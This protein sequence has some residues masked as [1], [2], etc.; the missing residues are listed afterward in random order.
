[1]ENKEVMGANSIL[2]VSDNN[3]LI[4]NDN[5]I[6]LVDN[7]TNLI[8]YKVIEHVKK[9]KEMSWNKNFGLLVFC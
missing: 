9:C 4:L 2:E 8:A 3:V 6:I 1:M 5:R 7:E